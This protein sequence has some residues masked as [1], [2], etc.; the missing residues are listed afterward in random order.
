MSMVLKV[1][2]AALT[3]PLHAQSYLVEVA[4]LE[5]WHVQSS[6]FPVLVL[7]APAIHSIIIADLQAPT[8]GL[9]EQAAAHVLVRLVVLVDLVVVVLHSGLVIL[10]V[11]LVDPTMPMV[12]VLT[13]EVVETLVLVVAVAAAEAPVVRDFVSQLPRARAVAVL[14]TT[15]FL[16]VLVEA[17]AAAEEGQVPQVVLN[18]EPQVVAVAEVSMV[19]KVNPMVS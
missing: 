18:Q 16:W 17:V 5:D 2:T 7:W 9:Q 3:K 8:V 11:V 12:A 14:P 15:S 10:L 6:G 19:L 1:A 4:V 13:A